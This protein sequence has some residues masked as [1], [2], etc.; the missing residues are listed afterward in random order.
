MRTPQNDRRLDAPTHAPRRCHSAAGWLP[1]A[2]IALAV[3]SM[4]CETASAQPT[5]YKAKL[6]GPVNPVPPV[7]LIARGTWGGAANAV[8]IEEDVDPFIAYL[9]SGRRLVILDVTDADN[10]IELGSIDLENTIQGVKVRDCYAYVAPTDSPNNFCVVD[11]SDLTNPRLVWSGPDPTGSDLEVD[12]YGDYAYA[13]SDCDLNVFDISDPE[14]AIYGGHAIGS[15]VGGVA[16]QGDL[17]YMV[18][19]HSQTNPVV[20]QLRIY[21]L[22]DDP[23]HPAQLSVVTLPGGEPE[24]RAVAVQGNYVYAVTMYPE[25]VLAIV[26]VSDPY[27]P[28]VTGHWG[29][30]PDSGEV[31]RFANDVA[32]SGNFAYVADWVSSTGPPGQALGGLKIFDVSDPANPTLVDT[33]YTHGATR[34]GIQIVDDRAYVCDEGEGLIILDISDY[35][36]GPVRLGNWHSPRDFRRMDKVGDLLYLTDKWNGISIVDVTDPDRPT[37]VGVYQTSEASGRWGDNWGIEVRDD[38]AYLGAGYGGL[39]IVDLS[40]PADPT[41]QGAFPWS[42]SSA[43][44][45]AV[46]LS[47]DGQIA[48]VGKA[49]GGCHWLVNFDVSDAQ[50]IA[51]LATLYIDSSCTNWWLVSNIVDSVDGCIAH[52][53]TYRGPSAIDVSNPA[54]PFIVGQELQCLTMDLAHDADLLYLANEHSNP[55]LGGLCIWDVSD[56][57]DPNELSHYPFNAASGVAVDNGLA[58]VAGG[59]VASNCGISLFDVSDP[60][61]PILLMELEVRDAFTVLVDG[62][63]VYVACSGTGSTGCGPG[64]LILEQRTARPIPTP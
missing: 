55:D 20:P 41:L 8:F 46:R 44:A 2:L 18:T 64:L 63:Y 48:R 40:N 10:I 16:I 62:R 11:V 15:V 25:G 59:M 51:E 56:P 35:R 53:A 39:E 36:G 5:V 38:L 58:Y 57:A 34:R 23:F 32:V 7:E 52:V 6:A 49:Y 9:G 27:A 30:D 4:C 31:F 13:R 24:A 1:T 28:F 61:V 29:D 43:R 54:A 26:D 3:I 14:N 17:M 21:D 12:L 60:S 37:L 33:Y 45:Q 19:Y 22:S 42:E 50:E 47:A